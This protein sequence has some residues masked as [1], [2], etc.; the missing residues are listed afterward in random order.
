MQIHNTRQDKPLVFSAHHTILTHFIV[1][2]S[3][4]FTPLTLTLSG[5]ISFVKHFV[6]LRKVFHKLS[7]L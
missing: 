5:L 3:P 7:L 2:T 6:T 4:M 1:F